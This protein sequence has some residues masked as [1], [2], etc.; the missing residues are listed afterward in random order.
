MVGIEVA[1]TRRMTSLAIPT[2]AQI[3]CGCIQ[4][5]LAHK[6]LPPQKDPVHVV[7]LSLGPYGD[8]RGG[9]SSL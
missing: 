7:G 9:S 5:N 6:K 2:Q 8:P 1:L 3:R 4:G